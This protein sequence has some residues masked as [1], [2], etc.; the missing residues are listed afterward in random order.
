[1]R[2]AITLAIAI[3]LICGAVLALSTLLHE[4]LD[5]VQVA[6]V[7]DDGKSIDFTTLAQVNPDVVGWIEIEGTNVSQPIVAASKDD[8]RHY[9]DHAFDGSAH[10]AGTPYL[11]AD[12]T[13]GL[14][15]SQVSLVYG[16]HL[17]DDTMFSA[18]AEYQDQDFLEAHQHVTVHVPGH[19]VTYR[20]IAAR[21]VNASAESTVMSFPS[22]ASLREW[23][24]S[25]RHDKA[26]GLAG[27]FATNRV[28]E[29]VTCS[30]STYSNERTAV[31]AIPVDVDGQAIRYPSDMDR[32]LGPSFS[33]G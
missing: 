12:V 16:H 3:A 32:L 17:L 26:A 19:V 23:L 22:V 29:L 31:Y 10:Y 27:D 24:R 11:D 20:V 7:D 1:M 30:Y 4:P 13:A 25:I 18:L 5:P 6:S 21:V 15:D 33:S 14:L 9:L 28:L 2:R 8:P